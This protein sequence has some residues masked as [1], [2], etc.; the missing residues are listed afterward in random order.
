MVIRLFKNNYLCCKIDFA[1]IIDYYKCINLHIK[2]TTRLTVEKVC[3]MVKIHIIGPV[4]SGKSTLAK[5]LTKEFFIPYF[6]IDNIVWERNPT[7]DIRRTDETITNIIATILEEDA[8]IIEGVHTH[9]WVEPLLA[10]AHKIIYYEPSKYVRLYRINKRFAKQYLRIE[11]SNYKP[12]INMLK[13]M[14][15][16]N[17][18]HEEKYQDEIAEILMPFHQ[19]LIHLQT[20]KDFRKLHKTF[21]ETFDKSI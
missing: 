7:G 2:K 18:Q 1:L 11:K 20:K 9:S 12:T 14:H 17:N 6:E 8:W 13:S 3:Y 4:G 16:W 15:K 5:T 10:E 19:K 21:Q